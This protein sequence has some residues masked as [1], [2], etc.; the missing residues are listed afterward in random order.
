MYRVEQTETIQLGFGLNFRKS[1]V[2]HKYELCEVCWK[3]AVA[4]HKKKWQEGEG[5]KIT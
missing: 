5:G 4:E 1:P 2:C 3:N